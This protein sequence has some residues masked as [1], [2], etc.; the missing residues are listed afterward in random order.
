[1]RDERPWI[2]RGKEDDSNKGNDHGGGGQGEGDDS[3]HSDSQP[4]AI[5]HGA[6][7]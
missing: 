1:M 5:S 3:D 6:P 2:L 4:S 7:Q